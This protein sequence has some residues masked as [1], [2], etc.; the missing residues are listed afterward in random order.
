MHADTYQSFV[1]PDPS[2]SLLPSVSPG[3]TQVQAKSNHIFLAVDRFMLAVFYTL[4]GL[5]LPPAHFCTVSCAL[6]GCG[7]VQTTPALLLLR[8][9]RSRRQLR[10]CRAAGIGGNPWRDVSVL[11]T[12]CVLHPWRALCCPCDLK[13]VFAVAVLRKCTRCARTHTR[14]KVHTQH[15]ARMRTRECV[16]YYVPLVKDAHGSGQ[17][18]K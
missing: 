1:D 4:C 8:W 3:K 15:C 13:L 9:R 12:R 11:D 14:T 7:A 17:V 10:R 18:R 2:A 16:F 6:Y 5:P